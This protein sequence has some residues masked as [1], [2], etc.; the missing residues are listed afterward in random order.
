MVAPSAEAG[1]IPVCGRCGS[2]NVK[3]D[4]W[5][6]WSTSA[7]D[8]ELGAVFDQAHCDNCEG[9]TTL[10]WQAE[11]VD[12]TAKI[13]ALNDAFRTGP[14]DDGMIVIT[15]GIRELGSDFLAEVTAAVAAFDKFT[16]DN[17]PHGEHDFGAL[18]MQ[19]EKVFWKFDYYDLSLSAHSPDAA[20]PA[21]TRRVLTIMLAHEY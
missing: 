18:D 9:E 3:R 17:D 16:A 19:G 7:Q 13:R 14:S 8:W 1:D 20:D 6:Q 11:P 12:K 21:V 5:A 4:A 2:E 15:A 10:V